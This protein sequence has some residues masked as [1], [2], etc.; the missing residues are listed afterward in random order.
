[1]ERKIKKF[2][3]ESLLD[4]HYWSVENG[5]TILTIHGNQFNQEQIDYFINELGRHERKTEESRFE[6]IART[7]E[8][9]KK[10]GGI[11]FE[12]ASALIEFMRIYRIAI[13]KFGFG[14][15]V[16]PYQFLSW[17]SS[18]RTFSVP[19]DL[20]LWLEEERA[21]LPAARKAALEAENEQLKA[22]ITEL[23]TELAAC[24]EQLE[25]A[26]REIPD[27]GEHETVHGED[28]PAEY[29]GHGI[30]TMVAKLVDERAPVK[31]IMR[32]LANEK[33][34]LSNKEE[35][36]FFHPSPEGKAASTLR[37]Y[38]KNRLKSV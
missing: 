21:K 5:C 32:L 35:G 7:V 1:M 14:K 30:F 16:T 6:Y 17:A 37:N 31:D 13:S 18:R 8:E 2:A 29:E 34:F 36:Y 19:Q 28:F 23:E 22:R 24:R 12:R 25:E 15:K 26:R 3:L 33:D 38:I 27:K 4:W 10:E 9:I 20:R 11:L